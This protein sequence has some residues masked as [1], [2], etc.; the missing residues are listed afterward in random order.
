MFIEKRSILAEALSQELDTTI[1]VEL[2]TEEPP[3]NPA[4]QDS[5]LGPVLPMDPVVQQA[6]EIFNA[7]VHEVKHYGHE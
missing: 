4:P 5:A 2:R 7:T 6:I 3:K 1:Q